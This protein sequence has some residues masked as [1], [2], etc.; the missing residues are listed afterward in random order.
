MDLPPPPA[1]PKAAP[2]VLWPLAAVLLAAAVLVGTAHGPARTEVVAARTRSVHEA[3]SGS[4]L[5][6]TV[7]EA[8]FPSV[9]AAVG[10]REKF[11]VDP[12]A[13]LP[14][15]GDGED[16]LA[17]AAR[18]DA[19]ALTSL[20]V[21]RFGGRGSE[22]FVPADEAVPGMRGIAGPSAGLV[23]TLAGLDRSLP[24][25][26]TGGLTVAATGTVDHLGS[27][28]SVGSVGFKSRAVAAAGAD[29]MFVPV[30]NEADVA[31]SGVEALYTM[32]ASGEVPHDAWYT[33][34]GREFR[35]RHATGVH[36][37][38]VVPVAHV[39]D[40]LWW[41]CGATG[42][43]QLCATAS[44]AVAHLAAVQ[45]AELVRGHVAELRAHLERRAAA[46]YEKF[47]TAGL[48]GSY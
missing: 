16:A 34:A 38:Q 8:R 17:R 12:T 48:S 39:A 40:A 32:P 44:A 45:R 43:P 18:R 31:M 11:H 30:V 25:D 19:V 7:T 28:G 13:P 1:A 41:L 4:W 2:S 6:V 15:S 24:V 33:L 22:A 3:G 23:L 5:A 36:H 14:D 35:R 47:R 42:Q 26:M 37:L 20:L 10:S 46:E 21:A 9:L 29:V 27:V